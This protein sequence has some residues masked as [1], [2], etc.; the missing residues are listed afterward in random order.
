MSI[1]YNLYSIMTLVLVGI[2][3]AADLVTTLLMS[4][5]NCIFVNVIFW[6]NYY[7]IL[8]FNALFKCCFSFCKRGF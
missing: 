1:L 5:F 8:F 6:L 7:R 3:F 4:R 2:I